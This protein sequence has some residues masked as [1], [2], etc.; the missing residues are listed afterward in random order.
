MAF[1]TGTLKA[2]ERAQPILPQKMQRDTY[3]FNYNYN[4]NELID[5]EFRVYHT[6]H[7]LIKD[8]VP[9][10]AEFKKSGDRKSVV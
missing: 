5:S 7:R 6:E 10:Y 1:D 9:N 3:T 4:P 8:E 2:G